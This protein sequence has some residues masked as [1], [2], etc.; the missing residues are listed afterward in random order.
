MWRSDA[1]KQPD[2]KRKKPFGVSAVIRGSA[3]NEAHGQLRRQRHTTYTGTAP[4]PNQ[5]LDTLEGYLYN[6]AAAETQTV[7]KGGPLAELVASLAIS[8]DTVARHQQ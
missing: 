2:K 1:P 7:T 3:V 8:V 6:I 4:L 5:M